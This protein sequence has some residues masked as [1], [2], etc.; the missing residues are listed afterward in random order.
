MQDKIDKLETHSKIKYIRV[1]YRGMN[2]FH[3]GYQPRTN[4]AKDEKGDCI[5]DSR[6]S[7]SRWRSHF[8]QLLNVQGT[9]EVR[10]TEIRTAEPE[11]AI[12]NL[13]GHKEQSTD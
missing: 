8:S 12:E 2:D 7:L 10:Q 11:M 3:R 9:R 6:S 13:E 1:S 5:T 4:I